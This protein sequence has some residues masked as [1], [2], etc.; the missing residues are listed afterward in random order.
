MVGFLATVLQKHASQYY[1]RPRIISIHQISLVFSLN[2]M[3][4]MET[5]L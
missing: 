2:K 1:S 4:G 3:D 5:L